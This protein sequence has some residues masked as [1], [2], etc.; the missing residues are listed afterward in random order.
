GVV[1]NRAVEAAGPFATGQY[2]PQ[3]DSCG[4]QA[5]ATLEVG[6]RGIRADQFAHER[7]EAV[8]RMRVVLVR[9]Q[10]FQSGHAAEYQHAD[11]FAGDRLEAVDDRL[12]PSDRT[13][14]AARVGM[15]PRVRFGTISAPASRSGPWLVA[16]SS[17][18]TGSCTAIAV[19]QAN[20]SM[21]SRR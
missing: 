20:C 12:H 2:V 3:R 8:L 4:R 19:S 14:Q 16:K 5:I 11:I 21:R 1:A 6:Q 10:R 17:P 15:F 18:E 7:P 9:L 13:A